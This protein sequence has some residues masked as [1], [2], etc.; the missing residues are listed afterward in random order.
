MG[1]LS[2]IGDAVGNAVSDIGGVAGSALGSWGGAALGN[3]LLPGVGGVIG[4]ALGGSLGGSAGNAILGNGQQTANQPLYNQI[5]QLGSSYA[6]ANAVH[7]SARRLLV[8][9]CCSS[10]PLTKILS[11]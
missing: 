2:S 11:H 4:S 10:D 9:S 5:G 3:M 1:F 7:G 8:P 6:A